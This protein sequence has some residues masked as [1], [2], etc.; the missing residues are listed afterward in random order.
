[1]IAAILGAGS[2]QKSLWPVD[3]YTD[4]QYVRQGITGWIMAGRRRLAHADKSRSR[5]CSIGKRLDA[6]LKTHQVRWPWVKG[7]AGHGRER[8]APTMGA[9]RRRH[10]AMKQRW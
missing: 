4:S 9:G 1:V 7:H 10:G 6:A 5:N 2:A 3:L 8:N